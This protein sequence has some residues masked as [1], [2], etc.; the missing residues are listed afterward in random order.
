VDDQRPW[1]NHTVLLGADVPLIE[2]LVGLPGLPADGFHVIALP[3][4]LEGENG[5]P[6]RVVAAFDA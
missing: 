6:A 2:N 3:L 5:G 1:P 4:K